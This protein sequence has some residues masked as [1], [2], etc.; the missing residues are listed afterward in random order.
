MLQCPECASRAAAGSRFCPSC[1]AGLGDRT[2]SPTRTSLE[3]E[4]PLPTVVLTSGAS[5]ELVTSHPSL[6]GARFL[7]GAMLADRYRVIALL[8]R[9]G[10]G[11]VY[12]ADDLKLGQPVALKFLPQELKQDDKRLA[13]FLNEVKIA[14]QVSHANVCRVYDVGDV[15]GHHYLSMEYVDG[16]DL[17]S[18]LRR[19]GRLPR[20][21]AVQV[22]RQICAGVAAAHEQGILH[23][24]LKP[25]N[26]MIDGRGRVKITDFGLAGLTGSFEGTEVLSGTPAYMSPEQFAGREVTVRSD[27]YAL[28]LVLYELFTGKPAFDAATP[29]EVVRL[30]RESAPTNPSSHVEG[31]DPAVERVI[32]RCLEKEPRERPASALAVAAALPGGDPL[33]AALAAGETPSPEMVADA[34]VT[35]GLRPPVAVVCLALVLLGIAAVPFMTQTWSLIHRVPLDLPPEALTIEAR[36]IVR[37]AGYVDPPA[38]T[39]YGFVVDRDYIEHVGEQEPA[40]RWR[41]V[42]TVRPA[43]IHFWYRQSPRYLTPTD[44]ISGGP[45]SPDDP[46][47]V[48]S[49]MVGVRLDPQGRLLDFEAVPPEVDDSEEAG[50]EPQWLALFERAGLDL[51]AFTPARPTWNSLGGA[52]LRRAWEGTLPD[53]S[54]VPVKVEAGAYRGRPTFFRIVTPWTKPARMVSRPWRP[55][56][57]VGAVFVTVLLSVVLVGGMLLARRNLRLGRGDRRG[58]FR[59]ALVVFLCGMLTWALGADHQPTFAEVGLFFQ[60]AA[61]MLLFGGCTWLV[62]IALEPYVRKIWPECIISWNRVVQGRLRDPLVGRDVLI[63][64]LTGLACLALEVP[65]FLVPSWLDLPLPEPVMAGLTALKGIRQS[66]GMDF[67]LIISGVLD[68][69]LY[70]FL[71]LLLRVILRKQWA[72]AIAL[73]VLMSVP[74][75]LSGTNLAIEAARWLLYNGLLVFLVVRFGMLAFLSADVFYTARFLHPYTWNLSAWYAGRSLFAL[76][77]LAALAVYAFRVSLAGRPLFQGDLFD[78]EATG[79]VKE[80]P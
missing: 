40:V 1:G 56:E 60:N 32:L 53:A 39:A 15:D 6:D 75:I 72:A 25:A 33:A 28:G 70:L 4:S 29:A 62:Y 16:E 27:L 76:S 66:I 55:G 36:E 9:G 38:D 61:W 10:M 52:D 47:P 35:G 30:Q 23:R 57:K 37:Q 78:K 5:R 48:L 13:R 34:G 21:K 44:F 51:A 19:I 41:D 79:K 69:V 26:V 12:R 77:L 80:R 3:S 59:V 20:D 17:S 43:P 58:A 46:A 64:A 71:L 50:S 7:P 67:G 31:L 14:R 2:S 74:Q 22:A 42:A 63:G 24:D 65:F 8:G 11:E 45:A 18:L 68:T 54:H 49:G 73:V